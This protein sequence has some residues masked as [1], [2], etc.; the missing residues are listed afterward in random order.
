MKATFS[1]ILNSAIAPLAERFVYLNFRYLVTVFYRIDQPMKKRLKT[2][3]KLNIGH[4]IASYSDVLQLNITGYSFCGWSHGNS[5]FR[6]SDIYVFGGG[7]P[8]AAH[9]DIQVC[10][11]D[12]F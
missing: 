10:Y 12:G 7:F 2:L 9:G 11:I 6:G 5:T 1:V 4:C 8:R 3:K